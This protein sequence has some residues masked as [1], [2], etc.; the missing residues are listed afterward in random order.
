MTYKKF[1]ITVETSWADSKEVYSAI[2]EEEDEL[3]EL[4][5]ELS[6]SNFIESGGDES[7]LIEMYPNN[8]GEYSEEE[9]DLAY[10]EYGNNYWFIIEEIDE[11][12]SEQLEKFDNSELVYDC[13]E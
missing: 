1:L 10:E 11:E 8:E 2:A 12:N 7:I 4:G 13:R 9:L 6:Y 3:W 5:E